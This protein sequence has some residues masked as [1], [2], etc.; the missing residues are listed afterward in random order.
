MFVNKTIIILAILFSCSYVFLGNIYGENPFAQ[1][2]TANSDAA[3][4][5]YLKLRL[6]YSKSPEYNPYSTEVHDIM[7]ECYKLMDGG[8]FKEAIEKAKAGLEK[9]KYNIQLLIGLAS[10]YRKTGD[11]ENADKFR[12]LWVGLISSILASGDGKTAAGAFKVISVDEEYAVLEVLNLRR[13]R[14]KHV[15][16]DGINFDIL[17]VKKEETGIKFDLYFDIDI[18]FKWLAKSMGTIK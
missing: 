4:A 9:D 12:K 2:Q 16:I 8:K 15:V 18:P 1:G 7:G 10:A 5:E 6:D 3:I 17:E 13:T 11:I 14:Q